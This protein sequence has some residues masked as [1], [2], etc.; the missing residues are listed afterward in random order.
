[1]RAFGIVFLFAFIISSEAPSLA[2]APDPEDLKKLKFLSFSPQDKA[3]EFTLKDL[4]G[5]EVSLDLYRGKPLMLY[6]WATW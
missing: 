1:M 3:P 5:K 4:E 6:F 2:G